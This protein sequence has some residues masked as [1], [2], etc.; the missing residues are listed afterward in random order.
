MRLLF[1]AVE[2]LSVDSRLDIRDS[3]ESLVEWHVFHLLVHF[4]GFGLSLLC[5]L[6]EYLEDGRKVVF[7]NYF[8]SLGEVVKRCILHGELE[9][10]NSRHLLL[11]EPQ[12]SWHVDFVKNII[13]GLLVVKLAQ[14][15][16]LLTLGCNLCSSKSRL[17]FVVLHRQFH[18]LFV[19]QVV[20]ADRGEASYRNLAR[21]TDQRVVS[22][23]D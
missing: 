8:A 2:V 18:K 17:E 22:V 5:S 1:N 6:H 4:V 9:Y 12:A 21:S 23:Y 11:S 20:V 7:L 19:A 3:I 15:L 10:W 13:V 16:E 14:I